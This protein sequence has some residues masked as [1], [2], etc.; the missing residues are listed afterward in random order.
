[1]TLV[2]ALLEFVACA[3][4]VAAFLSGGRSP[5]S[6]IGPVDPLLFLECLVARVDHLVPY[7]LDAFVFYRMCEVSDSGNAHCARLAFFVGLLLLVAGFGC[8]TQVA[9]AFHFQCLALLCALW[10]SS[11]GRYLTLVFR[12]AMLARGRPA[13]GAGHWW[14]FVATFSCPSPAL[15]G[16]IEPVVLCEC[17]HV[18]SFA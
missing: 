17:H 5:R 9:L 6:W 8:V 14:L 13:V 3:A 12:W 7:S 18:L 11:N 4:C 15:L 2:G 10:C 16:S 1:M